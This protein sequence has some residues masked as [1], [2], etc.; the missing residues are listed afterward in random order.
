[1]K[2][3]AVRFGAAAI[4]A[5][6]ILSCAGRRRHSVRHR[7]A[8]ARRRARWAR[9]STTGASTSPTAPARSSAR[10]PGSGHAGLRRAAR[11]VDVR[12]AP[13]AHVRV[14]AFQERQ[15]RRALRL[16]GQPVPGHQPGDAAQH[17]GP[18]GP[19]HPGRLVRPE[20][21]R[22]PRQHRRGQLGSGDPGRQ[23]PRPGGHRRG[24]P[25]RHRQPDL[26]GRARSAQLMNRLGKRS[27][28][29]GVGPSTSTTTRRRSTASSSTTAC[30]STRGRS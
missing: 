2:V 4:A 15:E 7:S 5:G 24:G 26:P 20:V 29:A 19:A 25:A 22:P 30:R 27:V 10:R 9:S 21:R 6:A 1:M 12:H 17:R 11:A 23:D 18:A 28:E 16:P 3:F 8:Q 13:R 14:P